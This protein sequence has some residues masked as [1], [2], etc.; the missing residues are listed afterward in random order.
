MVQRFTI[1]FWM[2]VSALAWL[3]LWPGGAH[4][5]SPEAASPQFEVS[6]VR[7][8]VSQSDAS[9]IS[10]SN[11]GRFVATNVP[12]R[13]LILYAY[14]L[15]DH[16]LIG[17][18]DW[19]FEKSFDV[20]GTYPA[21]RRPTDHEIRVMLQNLLADRFGLRLRREQREL[22][23]LRACSRQEGRADGTADA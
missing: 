18:P 5:Q 11:P 13:F 16:Q 17:A 4:T 2:T 20:A 22:P 8:N 6:S 14:K 3:S 19:T 7:Q 23:G 21:E 10:S 12:V 9:N 1:V 15:M